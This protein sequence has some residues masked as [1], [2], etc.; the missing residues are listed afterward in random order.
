LAITADQQAVL[1]RI[2]AELP[3]DWATW[4]GGWP[5]E[6]EAALLDAVLSIRARYG[7]KHTGVRGAVERW[8]RHRGE[9]LDDLRAVVDCGPDALQS[10]IKN[11]Q[12]LPGRLR[13]R[14]A[15]AIHQAAA[16]LVAAGVRQAAE[17]DVRD[18]AHRAAY[19]GV[20]GLGPV[21][22]NYLGMLLGVDG[23]KAD[24][25][26]LR[27]MRQA[28]GRPCTPAEADAL[29][30]AAAEQPGVKAT[31]LDYAIWNHKRHR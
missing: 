22:W 30:R 17:L 15:D 2:A 20:P 28:L 26:I 18:Q 7:Q 16:A 25:W 9:M 29:L 19:L 14:L 5:G 23:I 13:L 27:F 3:A 11:G 24:T 1:D 6:I 8:R 10:I 12:T 31:T 21:T 4:P